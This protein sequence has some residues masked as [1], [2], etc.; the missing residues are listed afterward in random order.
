M[1]KRH[2]ILAFFIFAL[3]FPFLLLATLSRYD[4]FEINPRT[5]LIVAPVAAATL[6]LAYALYFRKTKKEIIKRGAWMRGKLWQRV[7]RLCFSTLL[8]PFMA[9]STLD[10]YG[11]VSV[12]TMDIVIASLA[13]SVLTSACYYYYFSGGSAEESGN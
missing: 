7:L 4:F 10:A 13:I 9:L 5:L 8:V 11:L 12:S 2:P 3:I 1:K 6:T